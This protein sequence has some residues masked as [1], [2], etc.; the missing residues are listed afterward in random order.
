MTRWILEPDGTI[1]TIDDPIQW[2]AA[3]KRDYRIAETDLPD[4]SW[5]STVFL[6]VDHS[7]GS[8]GPPVLFETGWFASRQDMGDMREQWRWCT[9]A[10]AR[11]GHARIADRLRAELA[12][13]KEPTT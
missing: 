2:A 3:R 8:G 12:P 7:F 10:E 11:E 4:G 1:L 6:G 13:P 5:L 9:E